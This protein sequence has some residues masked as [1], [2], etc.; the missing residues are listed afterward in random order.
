MLLLEAL[1]WLLVSYVTTSAVEYFP[2]RY[3]M[4]SRS[5]ARR[6]RSPG[7]SRVFEAHATLHH[8][9]FF[10]PGHFEHSQDP[11]ARYVSMKLGAGYMLGLSWCLWLPLLYA[12]PLGGVILAA[13]L[14]VDGA[15]WSAVHEEMHLPAGGWLSRTALFRFWSRYHEQH[16]SRPGT[17]YNI[18]CPLFDHLLGTYGGSVLV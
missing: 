3:A 12:R 14:A 1:G 17:N 18:L 4:H 5:L 6:L 8:G 7:L 10:A 16:H 9:R 2:H 15:L 11:A 13:F